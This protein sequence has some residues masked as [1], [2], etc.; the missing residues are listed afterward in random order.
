MRAVERLLLEAETD[1][2]PGTEMLG[3]VACM[4][5]HG[6]IFYLSYDAGIVVFVSGIVV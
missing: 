6:H 4:D 3:D 2:R 5:G 1:R